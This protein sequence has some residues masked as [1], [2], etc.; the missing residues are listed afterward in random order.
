VP[1]DGMDRVVVLGCCNHAAGSERI[2]VTGGCQGLAPPA[3]R[4]SERRLL[5]LALGLTLLFLV[6][7]VVGSI[8]TGSLALLADAG[9]MVTDAGALGLALFATWIA[10]RRA[11]PTKTF[12]YHRAEILAALFNAA[13]LIAL[14][15]YIVVE[16]WHRFGAPREVWTGPMLAIAT[17]GLAVNLLAAWLLLRGSGARAG[18][19]DD[20]TGHGHHHAGL[21]MRAAALH[22]AGDAL[23]SVAAIVAGLL[24]H[25][26]GLWLADP[27]A[28]VAVAAIVLVGAIRL[29]RSSVDI[30]LEGT[31][32]HIDIN[33]V[34]RAL[35]DEPGVGSVHD[36]HVWTLTSGVYAMS[37]HAH[38]EPGHDG[39]AVL[40]RLT[41]QLR[42]RFAIGHTTIQIEH[43]PSATA[44][45]SAPNTRGDGS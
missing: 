2:D 28:S 16:A 42:E 24:M 22:V 38:V 33:E 43:A 6:V 40:R 31:P 34:Q 20:H 30:L 8:V 4:A 23:G 36:L 18:D 14:A 21:N 1:I 17:V 13:A 27:I 5:G 37:C 44:P 32:A 26:L 35:C 25:F 9:H 39:Q 7:E 19:A 3:R 10:R 11:N 45:A 29:L 15:G 12:G 41:Q